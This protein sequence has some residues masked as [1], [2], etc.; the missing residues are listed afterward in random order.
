MWNKNEY[1]ICLRDGA[2]L[3]YEKVMLASGECSHLFPM[4][5]IGAKAEQ[6]AYYDCR[7]FTPLSKYRI[8]RT[9]DAFFIL[10]KVILIMSS[11]VEYLISPSKLLLTTD[12]VF[13]NVETGE[14]KIAY[15]PVPEGSGGVRRNLLTFISQLKSDI[16]DCR[17][18]YIDDFA[19]QVNRN[20]CRLRDLSNRIGLIR[21][22]LYVTDQNRQ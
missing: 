17:S 16:G 21:R 5:F 12:T 2:I 8:D 3:D 13:F 11:V 10:E 18:G 20:N 19:N 7:G 22:E 1:R 4:F 9:E 6:F 15:V 14:I